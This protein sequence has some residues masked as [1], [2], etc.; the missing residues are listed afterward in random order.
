MRIV[1]VVRSLRVGG[2]EQQLVLLAKGLVTRGHEVHVVTLE[3]GGSLAVE[4]GSGGVVVGPP[5]RNRLV[6]LLGMPLRIRRL[7]PDLIHSYLPAMNLLVA[8]T[9]WFYRGVPLVWGYRASGFSH[10]VGSRRNRFEDWLSAR[11]ASLVD[12]VICNSAA[13][14]EFLVGLGYPSAH[15]QVVSN[16]IDSQRFRP[17]RVAGETFRNHYLN[18]VPGPVVGMLARWDPAKGHE[19][20]LR[21]AAQVLRSVPS[22]Q[23]AVVGRHTAE[24]LRTFFRIA[25][26]VGLLGRIVCVPEVSD[27][28][29][30]LNAFDLLVSP[31][32]SEGFPN[33]LA[34]AMACGVPVVTTDVGDARRIVG[35]LCPVVAVG[36]LDAMAN[37][38]VAVLEG[39]GSSAD[40]LRSTMKEAFGVERLLDRTEELLKSKLPAVES[41]D[42]GQ[43]RRVA[44]LGNMNN[45]HFT[46]MRYLRDAG[47]DAHL[48]VF[49]SDVFFPEADSS[50]GKEFIDLM[51]FRI[52]DVLIPLHRRRRRQMDRYGG[53]IGCGA[54][55]ALCTQIGRQLDVFTPYGSDLYDLPAVRSRNP[56]LRLLE[57]RV[58]IL[59]R[60]G[61]RAS[62]VVHLMGANKIYEES[63]YQ[64][65]FR[66][67]RWNEV[68]PLVYGPDYTPDALLKDG[69]GQFTEIR[70]ERSFMAFAHGRHVWA[71]STDPNAKGNERLIRGW[72]SFVAREITRNPVLVLFE[73]GS[74]V[75][76]SRSLIA[77]LGCQDSVVWMP[78]MPRRDLMKGLAVCDVVCGEF[79][80]SWL[81]S[82]VHFEAL[83]LS[84]PIIAYRDDRHPEIV[85]GN[86][87]P[88]LSAREPEEI[89]DRLAWSVLCPDEAAQIGQD[90][91]NWYESEVARGISRYVDLFG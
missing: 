65:G 83:T 81:S 90:G 54:A 88:A 24:D 85:A 89:S 41:D 31:S 70:S 51:T 45:N 86:A 43:G 40:L 48:L 18:G 22:A 23:F 30:A 84:K 13:G 36:D 91:K 68:M 49:S 3:A 61:I 63:L 59:Q 39:G 77:D 52:R 25:G 4:A 33:V 27:P 1:F 78:K 12:L 47:V 5:P 64:T 82:G 6:S 19:E 66:G 56:V 32:K 20:F 2:A 15:I 62:S 37:A 57:W 46:L 73:Y 16:G 74:D 58:A 10:S 35:G 44:L 34:E 21:M 76:K 53:L 67:E 8:I 71:S 7:N 28:T 29:G 87:Y 60:R 50:S 80:H 75:D 42:P 17:D 26:E 11:V 79:E 14:Q 55:P 69:A 72:A 38:V 9:R